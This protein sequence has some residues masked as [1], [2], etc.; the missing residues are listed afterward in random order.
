VQRAR[1]IPVQPGEHRLALADGSVRAA[2]MA[3]ADDVAADDATARLALIAWAS[4]GAL[5]RP[6][7]MRAWREAWLAGAAVRRGSAAAPRW[8]LFA[9]IIGAAFSEWIIRRLR[10]LA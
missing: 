5:V 9:L 4:G 10:G 6:D 7:S 3:T 1:F 8:L 2:F